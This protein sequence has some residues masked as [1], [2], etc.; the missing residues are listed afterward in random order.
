MLATLAVAAAATLPLGLWPATP[1]PAATV[2]RD[3]EFYL[4]EP[5]DDYTILAVQPVSPPL[6]PRDTAALQRLAGVAVRLGADAVVLLEAMPEAAIPR[7]VATPLAGDG[8][9]GAVAYIVFTSGD[10]LSAPGNTPH[11]A[12]GRAARHRTPHRGHCGPAAAP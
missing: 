9:V 4:Q 7:D 5:E 3:V 12:G 6:G 8:R 1:G 10:D 2:I 11:W